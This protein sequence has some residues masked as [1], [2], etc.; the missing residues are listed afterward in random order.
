M[1]I[2]IRS[3]V[4]GKTLDDH[5]IPLP[6]LTFTHY[7]TRF[8]TP[9]HRLFRQSFLATFGNCTLSLTTGHPCTP[10]NKAPSIYHRMERACRSAHYLSPNPSRTAQAI[11]SPRVLTP[12]LS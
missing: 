12:I 7:Y 3:S 1:P 11:A 6:P 8:P 5:C 2:S 4:S 10:K 9:A